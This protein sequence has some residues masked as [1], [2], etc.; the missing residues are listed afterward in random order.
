VLSPLNFGGVQP[1][2]RT[3]H[4][5]PFVLWSGAELASH[6]RKYT[7]WQR[8]GRTGDVSFGSGAIVHLTG[9]S[10][11]QVGPLSR[12]FDRVKNKAPNE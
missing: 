6:K 1:R 3:E 5:V 11:V 10:D 9:T 8:P 7:E 2:T 4:T 12:P